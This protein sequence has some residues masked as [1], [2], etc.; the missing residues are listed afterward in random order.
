MKEESVYP[1]INNGISYSNRVITNLRDELTALLD[2]IGCKD[3]ISVAITGSFGRK[4]ASENSDL[5]YFLIYTDNEAKEKIT[6]KETL[7]NICSIIKKHVPKDPGTT[8]TFGTSPSELKS[9]CDNIGGDKETN[10]DLTRRL[11]LLLEGDWIYGENIF[12]QARDNLIDKYLVSYSKNKVPKFLLNDIIRYYRTI[13]V[14][15]QQKIG[16][17]KGWG[18]RN[19]KLRI[20]RKMLYFGGIIAA[21]E[22]IGID[23]LDRKEKLSNIIKIPAISRITAYGKCE[24]AN[25]KIL[26]A[27]NSFM[28][29]LEC[30]EV[31]SHLENLRREDRENSEVFK[32]LRQLGEDMTSACMEWIKRR[33]DTNPELLSHLIF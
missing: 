9:L 19:V 25:K 20:S 14:D 15:F 7:D 17:G 32:E 13:A 33:H 30:Q 1:S 11:L 8:G 5:D 16:E 12:N 31:R 29:K 28:T 6:C 26:T 27:Y 4:E 10:K 21:T 23:D 2:H 22:L 24:E 18:L 3:T